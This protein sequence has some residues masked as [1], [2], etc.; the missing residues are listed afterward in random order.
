MQRTRW[1]G[2]V[3]GD[4]SGSGYFRVAERNGVFWLVDPDGGR[5]LSK[6]VNTIRFDQ[7]RIGGTERVPYAEACRAKYGS[8]QTWRAAVSDRLAS[9]A[10]NTVG[11]WSDETRGEFGIAPAGNHAGRGARR[12]LPPAPARSGLP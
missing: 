5:F 4:L 3:D 12:V 6:G 10:F 7:E 8:L 11:C 9:W 1:G 2:V